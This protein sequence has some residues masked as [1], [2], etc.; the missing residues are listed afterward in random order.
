MPTIDE[1][2]PA[3]AASDTDEIPVS[4]GGIARKVTRSQLLAGVQAQIAMAAG[5]LLGRTSDGTGPSEAIG[6]GANLKLVAGTL[7]ASATPYN[8]NSSPAGTVPTSQDLVPLGQTGTNTVVSYAQFMAGI[9]ALS[10]LDA[11]GLLVT[12]TAATG[13]VKLADTAAATAMALPLA[14]AALPRSGGTLTGAV[15]LLA[16]PSAAMQPATKRYAD[17]LSALSVQKTANLGDVQSAATARSNLGL[18][19][20]ATQPANNIAVTGGTISGLTALDVPGTIST[21]SNAVLNG[22]DLVVNSNNHGLFLKDSVS[23]YSLLRSA[24]SNVALFGSLGKPIWS[25]DNSIAVG[26]PFFVQVPLRAASLN[27]GTPMYNLVAAGP[28]SAASQGLDIGIRYSGSLGSTEPFANSIYVASDTLN[29]DNVPINLAALKIN[30]QYGGAGTTGGRTGLRI[31]VNPIGVVG[32]S[33]PFQVGAEIFSTTNL[34]FGGTDL[35]GGA[36]GQLVPINTV[37]R[38][39]SGATNLVVVS[40]FGEINMGV[41]AGASAAILNG[42]QIS[43][44]NTDAGTVSRFRAMMFAGTQTP[45]GPVNTIPDMDYGILWGHDHHQWSFGASS[46]MIGWISQAPGTN[47]GG[48]PVYPS[49]LG[50]GVD[51]W[52]VNIVNQAWRST[53]FQI[54]GSGSVTIGTT[55]LSPSPQGLSINA[56][57][58]FVSSAA[59]SAPGSGYQIGEYLYGPTGDIYAVSALSGSGVSAVTVVAIGY[60]NTPPSNPV[61]VSGGSGLGATLT[62]GW[63]AGN[64]ITMGSPGQRI[65]FNGATPVA[66]PSVSGSRAGNAA[67]TSIIAALSAYGLITDTTIS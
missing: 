60:A 23:G 33:N 19:S 9:S 20:I 48:A 47:P 5:T 66:R 7:S 12:P 41:D 30:Y 61:V 22:A 29:S 10:G 26:S 36:R 43:R 63:T 49:K 53:G 15:T 55:R 6:I 3:T 67:L 21:S 31:A 24:S 54:D 39:Y 4:Q 32:G 57:G 25:Y 28:V 51:L 50:W 8:I 18:G 1:L 17:A 34:S 13:S 45:T 11:S 58:Q 27:T 40:G 42:F 46:R 65:G 38:A 56:S 2:A 16:D 35:G 64:G 59:T 52:G 37:G 14:L 62:L 44:L